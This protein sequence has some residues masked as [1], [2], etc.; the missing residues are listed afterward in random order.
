LVVIGRKTKVLRQEKGRGW[1]SVRVASEASGDARISDL[2]P[3]S[4]DLSSD[5]SGKEPRGS[6]PPGQVMRILQTNLNRSRAAMNLFYKTVEDRGISIAVI[7]EPNKKMVQNLPS[8]IEEC[9]DV[10]VIVIDRNVQVHKCDST[11]CFV[12]CHVEDI[13]IY[14][15]YISPNIELSEFKIHIRDL[16]LDIR[17]AANLDVIV[18]GDFNAKSH[19]WGSPIEDERGAI[20]VEW[21]AAEDLVVMNEG[22]VP[23]FERGGSSSFID[24]TMANG[25]MSRRIQKWTVTAEENL[26]DHKNI[27]IDILKKKS[28]REEPQA[29]NGARWKY[30]PSRM[31]R[32]LSRLGQNYDKEKSGR[33]PVEA[34]MTALKNAT[35]E[36]L[37]KAHTG[38]HRRKPVYWW[39]DEI[40]AMRKRC[41]K[42]RRTFTRRT[43]TKRTE[44]TEQDANGDE[45]KRA[46]YQLARKELAV[47]ITKAKNKKWQ[48]L[49]EEV[50]TDIWGTGWRIVRKKMS[51]RIPMS[52]EAMA[53]EAE[54]LFPT[55]NEPHRKLTI[56]EGPPRPF[57]LEEIEKAG[58]RLK[59]GKA[60]GPD[61]IPSEVIKDIAAEYPNILA[62]VANYC[63]DE[64]VFPEEWKE[65][66]LVLL[67]KPKKN[68]ADKP[69]YRPICLLNAIG[70]LLEILTEERINEHLRAEGEL[71][72][73]QYGFR[74]G[75]ST[76][77]PMR[78]I[79]EIVAEINQKSYRHRKVCLMI[80]FDIKNAFNSA[81][82]G[83]IRSEV[84]RWNMCGHI[85]RLVDEYLSG[86]Y[87]W[88][89]RKK[90]QVTRGVPQGSILGPLLW[91]IFY[92]GILNVT[93][94]EGVEL[95]GYADDLAAVVIGRDREELLSNAQETVNQVT[96][97]M[98]GMRLEVAAG[99]SEAVL[100]CKRRQ[101]D[102]L[103]VNINGMAIET[104]SAL[105]YLGVYF[106]TDTR[107]TEH[108]KRVASRAEVLVNSMARIL[109]NIGGTRYSKRRLMA[110]V[111]NSVVLYG[112]PI[113][114]KALQHKKYRE[115][116]EK[117]QRLM[118]LRVCSAYRT[119]STVALQVV[120]ALI[121]IDLMVEERTKQYQQGEGSASELRL[122]TVR[123]W[124]SR[125]DC[126]KERAQ[127]TK[128]RSGQVRSGQ[129]RSGQVRSPPR[130][131]ETLSLVE[132][133]K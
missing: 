123:L 100:L 63:L 116:L 34:F 129:V 73:R 113:W 65:A 120:G 127:W 80:T 8:V 25:V 119:V 128:R 102:S 45:E 7:S 58:R 133:L 112:A 15:C 88:V 77:D 122:Q 78:R 3:K 20:I 52:E 51:A 110:S 36:T 50:D 111:V 59:S 124:Q 98:R 10:A 11:K 27:E 46:A 70:K 55:G 87:L 54:R 76:L 81:E 5:R 84:D 57:G 75:R 21:L 29:G 14:G 4:R 33:T 115:R 72:E 1:V 42:A 117:V 126:E 6:R 67:E 79:N 106:D 32:L 60:P 9:C 41:M 130:S 103:T 31:P 94:P 97:W 96:R 38:K 114:Q 22:G 39:N 108:V 91:N 82:W 85:T 53:A 105:K 35:S 37:M 66:R 64:G 49:I 26:S 69:T 125:W 86:R 30:E 2:S 99:K 40:A 12:C 104:G 19:L 23:T 44:S 132:G 95:L 74:K 93:V 68:A 18:C 48:E 56:R 121:P 47:A 101:L 61:G 28:E 118:A 71:S 43:V 62:E 92:N 16:M 17:R 90:M 107:M 89:G 83:L 131:R 13:V 24:I 109:P